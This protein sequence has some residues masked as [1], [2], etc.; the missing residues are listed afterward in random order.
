MTV[1]RASDQLVRVVRIQ[2]GRRYGVCMA[3]NISFRRQCRYNDPRSSRIYFHAGANDGEKI[4]KRLCTGSTS[5]QHT[6]KA[7]VTHLPSFVNTT[8]RLVAEDSVIAT[9]GHD[10]CSMLPDVLAWAGSSV[11]FSW[12]LGFGRRCL[13]GFLETLWSSCDD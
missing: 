13:R 6:N 9:H 12:F 2:D 7:P 5:G 10:F 4:T 8:G 11:K 3:S 1:Q